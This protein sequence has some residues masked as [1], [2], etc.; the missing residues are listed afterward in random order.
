MSRNTRVNIVSTLAL[1]LSLGGCAGYDDPG[2]VAYHAPGAWPR[3]VKQAE[4]TQCVPYVRSHSSISIW[5]DAYTWW[6]KA[7]GRFGRTDEPRK[8]AILVMR[9]YSDDE[10]GH[11]AIVR[12]ILNDREIVVDHA[13]WLNRGEVGLDTPVKDVSDDNDWSEV[14]V[15]YTPDRHYGGRVYDVVGFILPART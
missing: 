1:L 15:W 4:P 14:R 13:N 8:G 3:I 9:G 12:K 7:A 6:D 11:V 5:G 2:P 10:R